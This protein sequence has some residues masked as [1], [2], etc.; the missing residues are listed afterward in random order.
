[1]ISDRNELKMCR[2]FLVDRLRLSYLSLTKVHDILSS[3]SMVS[4]SPTHTDNK[5]IQQWRIML[6]LILLLPMVQFVFPWHQELQCHQNRDTQGLIVASTTASMASLPPAP[7]R[8]G[9]HCRQHCGDQGIN[10]ISTTAPT[11]SLPSALRRPGHHCRQ[12]CGDQG[13]IVNVK[14]Y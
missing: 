11:A 6:P 10:V 2:N 9:P 8:P 4:W 12:H 3:C 14:Q 7:Q 5:C 13:I 1:M